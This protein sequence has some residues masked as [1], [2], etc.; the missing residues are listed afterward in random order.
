MALAD[1]LELDRPGAEPGSVE[2]R[3][4]RAQDEKRGQLEGRG[5]LRSVDDV[6]DGLI[7]AYSTGLA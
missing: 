4:E 7:L 1:P 2:D 3:L 5:L 6:A